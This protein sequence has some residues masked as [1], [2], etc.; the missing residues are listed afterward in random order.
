MANSETDGTNAPDPTQV[1]PPDID[2]AWRIRGIRGRDI[3]YTVPGLAIMA[4]GWL[5]GINTGHFT[6]G[7]A[8]IGIGA[9]VGLAGFALTVTSGE[10][11]TGI[12]RIKTAIGYAQKE[13]S[14]PKSQ[15]E[16]TTV[17]G[18]DRIHSDGSAE[19]EDDRIVRLAQFHG[20]NADLQ[21]AS[22][23]RSM[24]Q[25]VR[26]GL[27]DDV[28]DVDFRIFSTTKKF[29]PSDVTEKY[30]EQWLSDAYAGEEWSA[31]R[32]MLSD[33]I[34]WEKEQSNE[35]YETRKW[36]H[37]LVVSVSPHEVDVPEY[38]V[39]TDESTTAAWRENLHTLIHG[40]ES[41]G[42]VGEV[43]NAHMKARRRRMRTAANKRLSK[44]RQAFEGVDGVE[45]EA[46]G[47]AEYALLL[48]RYWSGTDHTF[49]PER[50]TEEVNV[51]VWPHYFS[52]I[53]SPRPDAVDDAEDM[54]P[55][56][57]ADVANISP[58]SPVADGGADTETKTQP[59]ATTTVAHEDPSNTLPDDEAT[60]ASFLAR[61]REGLLAPLQ[62]TETDTSG[63]SNGDIDLHSRRVQDMIAPSQ[64]DDRDDGTGGFVQVGDQYCRTYWIADWPVN[65]DEKFLERLYTMAGVDVDV[66]L[67]VSSRDREHTVAEV[68]DNI[69]EI[70][71]GVIERKEEADEIQAMLMEDS[72]DPHMT[73]FKLLEKTDVRPWAISG[74]VTVRVGTRHALDRAEE[75][76]EEGLVEEDNLTLDIAKQRA[77]EDAC[78]DVV[79]VLESTPA[80]LTAIADAQRQGELFESCSPTGRDAYADSSWRTRQRLTL[81][82]T[83]AA[84]FPPVGTYKRQEE[85]VERGR[86]KTNGHVMMPDPFEPGPA[87]KLVL[88]KTGS[89]KTTATL[90]MGIRWYL[91]DPDNRTLI[92]A[93]T[94][95]A[96]TGVTEMLNGAHIT[97]DGDTTLN[98][99]H[100]EPTPQSVLATS[101][102]DPFQMKFD[103]VVG[104]V[105]DI[106]TQTEAA[107]DKFRPLVKDAVQKAMID[108]GL[109]P[110]DPTTHKPENSPTLDDVRQAVADIADNADELVDFDLESDVIED[111]AGPLL[112][113]MSGFTP[114]GE[115]SFLTG[116]SDERIEVGGVTY[117]D[118]QQIEGL[119]SAADAS[120]MLNLALS[121]VYEAVK[122]A[123]G[124]TL[125][126]IDEAHYLLDSEE[127]LQWLDQASR[128]WRHND[129]GLWFCSQDPGDFAAAEDDDEEQNKNVIRSQAQ[130]VE[131]FSLRSLSEETAKVYQLN[132]LQRE[133]L[134][135]TATAGTETTKNYTDCLV[136][137]PDVEGWMQSEVRLSPLEKLI[138][139]EYDPQEHGKL[140]DFLA[141]RYNG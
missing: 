38:A 2:A 34:D 24:V 92:F 27:D 138:H 53:D 11:S 10:H 96:F 121:Q 112:R 26:R 74:Y 79:D 136:D 113:R 30:E 43:S 120:T 123:P 76:I 17:H 103:Q 80:K 98:P 124:K 46:V 14:H 57:V 104:L 58:I 72:I 127:M 109:D 54:S 51:S 116:S 42:A 101:N 111:K 37:Y 6:V 32:A 5:G 45:T 133:Y 141:Q 65:P 135:N 125:F 61:V 1:V 71:S 89:G 69:G 129:A 118:L 85:G 99:L 52:D 97:M 132:E 84:A 64:F 7:A 13:Q 82:G 77:L 83:I 115:Y 93:D 63:P 9:V 23:A 68:K 39:G 66:Q 106:I 36:Y 108:A 18:I 55:T 88:G 12:D 128:H 3:A 75:H 48:C 47:P 117:L 139:T 16:A 44:V 73:M 130:T 8:V 20:R 140:S 60:D 102:L 105:L 122:R 90:K 56:A 70:D 28:T 31:A 110:D 15:E 119:G 100:M 94:Q 137:Y 21:D 81:S 114:D 19:T 95:S 41:S 25:S 87:H 49:A 91:A 67:R 40:V 50:V 62:K 131:L 4:L 86:S 78:D 35:I 59:V 22:A 33:I 29:D 107:R 126:I 134:L